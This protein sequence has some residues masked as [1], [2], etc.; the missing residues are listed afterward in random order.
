[1][2]G[3][4]H[5]VVTAGGGVRSES[6]GPM[7][8]LQVFQVPQSIPTEVGLSCAY[9]FVRKT[10]TGSRSVL[11]VESDMSLGGRVPRNCDSDAGLTAFPSKLPAE[12]LA[13][14]CLI[15]ESYREEGD[16]DAAE[17]L[18]AW[19]GSV[20]DENPCQYRRHSSRQETNRRTSTLTVELS[21]SSSPSCPR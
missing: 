10:V 19:Q 7:R 11:E 8:D 14:H 18:E 6:S 13:C 15:E 12:L 21:T 3:R 17:L 2:Q 1:M 20:R 5:E 4:V 9:A 16:I